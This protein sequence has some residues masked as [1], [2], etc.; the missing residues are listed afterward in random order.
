MDNQKNNQDQFVDVKSFAE[1]PFASTSD[2]N[3]LQDPPL[4]LII[5]SESL[6]IIKTKLAETEE[7]LK[8]TFADYQN[9]QRRVQQERENM[10]LYGSENTLKALIP[11]LDNFHY[12]W[13]MQNL[14]NQENSPEKII[15]SFKMIH[16]NL[17]K[18]L[19]SVGVKIIEAIPGDEYKPEI[20]E[21]VMQ[22]VSKEQEGSIAQM[23]SPGY[24]LNNKIIKAAQVAISQSQQSSVNTGEN[25]S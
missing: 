16:N 11:T 9:L 8:R 18:S 21:A 15:E 13:Q 14:Q 5:D 4:G 17:L 23:L 19:E 2:D 24:S 22:M 7:Q 12:A 10:R 25:N 6:E 20:H 1:E 3:Q